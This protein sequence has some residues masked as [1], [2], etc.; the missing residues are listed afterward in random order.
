[1]NQVKAGV[2]TRR[3]WRAR[4]IAGTASM[5]AAPLVAALAAPS[6]A[7]AAEYRL[8]RAGAPPEELAAAV[9]DSLS[10]EGWRVAGPQG[11]LCEIWLRKTIP[12]QASVTQELGVAFGELAEGT[13]VGAIRFPGPASDF[14]RVRVQPGV[15]TMR[16]MLHPIDGYHMGVAAQRDF[17]V[18]LPAASDTSTATVAVNDLLALSRKA[19]GITHPTVWSLEAAEA[20]AEPFLLH[21]EEEDHWVVRFPVTIQPEGGSA[22][23]KPMGFVVAGHAPE[24]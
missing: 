14:R 19:S 8:E 13:L 21:K 15:Y 2:L 18:L 6:A 12:A 11:P 3:I 10:A 23:T 24:A 1:M 20:A 4:R 16:Y 7:G 17:V 9:R 5:L 22:T